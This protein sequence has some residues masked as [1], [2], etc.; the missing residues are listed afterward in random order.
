M[1]LP[2]FLQ[3]G[4]LEKRSVRF[5]NN[6][7]RRFTAR[8]FSTDRHQSKLHAISIPVSTTEFNFIRVVSYH[9]RKGHI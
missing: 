9:H 5:G 8:F 6:L 2:D 4:S 3:K 7:T 1:N